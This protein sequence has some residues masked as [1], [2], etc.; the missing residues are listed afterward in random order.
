MQQQTVATRWG[1]RSNKRATMQRHMQQR[2][3]TIVWGQHSNELATMYN[4]C[5]QVR[6]Y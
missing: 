3:V 2:V 5:T 4:E 1:Q 6:E